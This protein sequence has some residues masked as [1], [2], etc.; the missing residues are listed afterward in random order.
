MVDAVVLDLDLVRIRPA[1]WQVT[2]QL[3][4][5][6]QTGALAVGERLPVEAQLAAAFGVSRSTVREALRSLGSEGLVRT[7]RGATG[8]TFVS[9]PDDE[10]LQQSI[11]AHL[12]LMTGAARLTD[13]DY[14]DAR[15][16]IEVP[17]ARMAAV[18][19]TDDHLRLMREALE[20]ERKAMASWERGGHSHDFHTAVVQ[21]TGN[22]LLQL[23]TV[24]IFRSMRTRTLA[25]PGRDTWLEV[26][27][28]HQGI[29]RAV[30]DGDGAAAAD[31]MAGHIEYLRRFGGP[32]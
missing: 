5:L 20:R 1:Y 17:C 28:A 19:R 2:D 4:E 25:R 10:R 11:E 7:I 18:R 12:G 16:L 9:V 3:R 32:R 14:F 21:A 29:L 24:P 31:A 27:D 8:G 23:V 13:D 22:P 26:D 30:T 6:I 15:E